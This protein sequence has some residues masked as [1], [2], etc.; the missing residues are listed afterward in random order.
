MIRHI[1]VSLLFF[2]ACSAQNNLITTKIV[3]VDENKSGLPE[4]L[5]KIY[6]V[7]TIIVQKA[8][9]NG[10]V[11][12]KNIN[13]G[14]YKIDVTATGYYRI[15]GY[16]I[17][18]KEKEEVVEIEMLPAVNNTDIDVEWAGGWVTLQDKDGKVKCIRSKKVK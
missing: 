7:D 17:D 16:S 13:Y 11:D 10:L 4:A 14:S 12:L 1:F 5:V 8:D 9:L 3:V 18:L 6:N 2:V 15:L